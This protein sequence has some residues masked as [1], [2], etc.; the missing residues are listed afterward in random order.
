[1]NLSEQFRQALDEENAEQIE[2]L[3][4]NEE[5][6]INKYVDR[7][8]HLIAAIERDNPCIV[9]LILAKQTLQLGGTDMYARTALMWACM[10][11]SLGKPS[12]RKSKIKVFLKS[13]I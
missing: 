10:Q 13:R 11:N 9:R 6:D 7:K 8:T 5:F 4:K 1:M 3:L 2:K 12:N